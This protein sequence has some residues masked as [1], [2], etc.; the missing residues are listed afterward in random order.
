M[1]LLITVLV[2]A[3]TFAA[4]M[5]LTYRRFLSGTQESVTGSAVR[6]NVPI[7]ANETKRYF[8]SSLL[9]N[10]LFK[11]WRLILRDP[12]LISQTALQMLYLLPLIFLA[13]RGEQ[14]LVYLVPGAVLLAATLAG[15]LAWITV[16]AEDAPELVG[17]APVKAQ[18]VRMMK[19]LAAMIPVWIF[20]APMLLF[21]L[22]HR[23][24]HA[25]VF[26][27]C[28]LGATASAGVMQVWY[29]RKAN[30]REMKKRGQSETLINLLEG[31]SA[32]AWSGVAWA[33]VIDW[34]W[35]WFA[36]LFALMVALVA[37]VLV[38]QLGRSRRRQ[39]L[40]AT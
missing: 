20:V 26:V 19:A 35:R 23:P 16:A 12:Q 27:V 11:E 28:T 38:W 30:R 10:V 40:L 9:R 3:G 17:S 32:F 36:A 18:R 8:R 1:P 6:R 22:W 39:G 29:P 2:G 13:M 14:R 24:A 37:P 5:A 31:F 34:P 33:L 25:V 15:S 7:A 4:V 21:L